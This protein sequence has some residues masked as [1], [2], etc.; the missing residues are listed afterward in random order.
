M[1]ISSPNIVGLRTST[2]ASRMMS[3]FVRSDAVVGEVPHAVLD[4]DDRAVDDQAEVDG[5]Q[6]HQARRRCRPAPSS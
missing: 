4:H 6:A 2:A 1:M 5:P 3:S